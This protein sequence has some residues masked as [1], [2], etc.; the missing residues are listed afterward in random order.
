MVLSP[1][2]IVKRDA[3][4]SALQS[5]TVRNKSAPPLHRFLWSR[6]IEVRP[7]FFQSYWTM[8]PLFGLPWGLCMALFVYI[9]ILPH[10]NKSTPSAMIATAIGGL[11]F[12]LIM[13][14]LFRYQAKKH[15]LP[16]W[17]DLPT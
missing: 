17:E 4:M 11:A 14:A 2:F 13:A 1:E 15:R 6:G 3:A 7:P 16:H 9:G 10:S 12:G 8:V 5:S